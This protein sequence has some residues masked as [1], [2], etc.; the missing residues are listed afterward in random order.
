MTLWV[1]VVVAGVTVAVVQNAS[2][3]PALFSAGWC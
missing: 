3:S 1:G 2:L